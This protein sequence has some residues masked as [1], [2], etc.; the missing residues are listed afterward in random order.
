MD[1]INQISSSQVFFVIQPLLQPFTEQG[2]S[3][4]EEAT[5]PATNPVR[6]YRRMTQEGNSYSPGDSKN[7]DEIMDTKEIIPNGSK[8]KGRKPRT[9]KAKTP[10]QK[11]KQRTTQGREEL[12]SDH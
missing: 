8:R 3:D 12:T 5:N 6:L 10:R 9:D 1:L 7:I 4:E 2:E 11:F